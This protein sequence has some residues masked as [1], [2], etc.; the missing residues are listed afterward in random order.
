MAFVDKKESGMKTVV[1]GFLTGGTQACITYPT[2]F[3]KTQL[4]LQS[5]APTAGASG[6]GAAATGGPPPQRFAWL[7]GIFGGLACL[8][9]GGVVHRDVK[10][11]NLLLR[12][13]GRLE[14]RAAAPRVRVRV[15]NSLE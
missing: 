7:G 14:P 10:L 15:R 6:A 4:Q 11:E 12:G 13:D 8:H 1:K 2:E 5:K 3:V 9:A